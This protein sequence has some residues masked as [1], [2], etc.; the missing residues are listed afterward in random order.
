MYFEYKDRKEPTGNRLT[1][2]SYKFPHYCPDWSAG[3]GN[4]GNGGANGQGGGQDD[5]TDWGV[6]GTVETAKPRSEDYF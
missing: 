6:P 5:C 3:Q 1:G 2:M 4:G